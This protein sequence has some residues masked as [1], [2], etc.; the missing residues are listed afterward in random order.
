MSGICSH[1]SLRS[2]RPLGLGASLSLSVGVDVRGGGE[3]VQDGCFGKLHCCCGSALVA[4]L[5][6]KLC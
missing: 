1:L 3:G 5:K 2:F 4:A 6:Y